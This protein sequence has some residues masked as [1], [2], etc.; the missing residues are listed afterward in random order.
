MLRLQCDEK[1]AGGEFAM[2]GYGAYQAKDG[3]WIY[4]LILTDAH[5]AKLT[6][7]LAMPDDGNPE[8][9]RLRDRKKQRERVEEAVSAAVGALTYEEAASKLRVAGLVFNEVMP[10]ERVLEVP[11][12]R[13]PGKLRELNYRNYQFEVP[14]FPGQRMGSANLPPPELGQHTAELLSESGYGEA[15]AAALLESGAA[16]TSHPDDFPWAPVRDKG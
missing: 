10:L 5:W 2:P 7:A 6:K 4:L 1:E 13:Q 12:A 3:R 16:R 11:Q 8:L 15:E 14:E 9:A